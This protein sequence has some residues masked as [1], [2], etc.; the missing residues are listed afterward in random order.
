MNI[1]GNKYFLAV[2]L[3]MH[4]NKNANFGHKN[5]AKIMGSK[6]SWKKESIYHECDRNGFVIFF[7]LKSFF[8]L[9]RKV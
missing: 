5:Y 1:V 9:V 2:I 7:R 4:D 6:E 8:K 3:S